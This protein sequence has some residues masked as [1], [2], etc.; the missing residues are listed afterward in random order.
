MLKAQKDEREQFAQMMSDRKEDWHKKLIQMECDYKER[1]A[2]LEKVRKREEDDFNYTKELTR[3]KENDIYH[4]KRA[5]LEK[6]IIEQQESLQKR[7]EAIAQQE[8]LLAQLQKK[9]ETFDQEMDKRI[10]QA[11]DSLSAKLGQKHQFDLDLAERD[12]DTKLRLAEQ[13]ASYLEQKIQEQDPLMKQL[14]IK[15]NEA[16]AQMQQIACR[17]LD[18]SA[19]RFG[20]TISG[21]PHDMHVATK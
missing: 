8:E 18:T 15:M 9:V 20:Q 10:K 11:E 5:Q 21:V 1:S 19:Q 14:N 16:S 2:E 7:E 3:R 6:E 13:K 17:A 4:A 12:A